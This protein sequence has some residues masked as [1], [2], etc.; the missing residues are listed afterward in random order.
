MSR[1]GS[2]NYTLPEAAFTAGTTIESAK[3]NSNF[4]D[5][6][7]ALTASI[8]KD[9]QTVPTANLPMGSFK[10]TGVANASSRTH[11]AAAGQIAD[12]SLVYV[13]DT[14]SADAYAIAPAPGI[15]AYAVGQ[16]F[17]F[18][19]ANSNLTTT[20]T[21]AVNGLTAGTIKWPNGAAL[22]AGDLPANALV[23]VL[24]SAVT[25]GTP[26][27]HLQTAAVRQT[28]IDYAPYFRSYI[29]GLT[30]ST[31]G[32]S[33]TF[34]IAAG[35]AQD[36]TNAAVMSL[37]SAYTKTT[38]S[39][40]VGSGNGAL[41]TGSIANNTWYH[42]YLIQRSDTSVVDVLISTSASSPTMPTNYDRKRR[43]GSMKTN[44]SA[45]WTAFIQ[46]G[47]QFKWVTWSYDYSGTSGATTRQNLT[48]NVPTGVVV[49]PLL[50]AQNQTGAA[51]GDYLLLTSLDE[52]DSTPAV[53]LLHCYAAGASGTKGNPAEVT[54]LHTD[55]SARIGRRSFVTDAPIDI[56]TMGWVDTRGRFG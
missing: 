18:K 48:L 51:G 44:G 43:I 41:D 49:F 40:A 35:L 21:L 29:A 52:T 9:G 34:G 4:S 20:P 33:A 5:I 55:T 27:F 26:T 15:S 8:A 37:G 22:T 39:W 45:Q 25:T 46:N 19:V 38:S 50:I 1:D 53:G 54:S 23:S 16:R 47:D 3:V 2:G 7:A 36:S 6:Q 24:V 30:L 13:A 10:H 12:N 28:V 32:S 42:V 31:A 14:G 11:Y 56:Q 17:D